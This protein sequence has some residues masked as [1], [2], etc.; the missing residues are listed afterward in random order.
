MISRLWYHQLDVYD[1]VR[2]LGILLNL[3]RSSPG[4]ERLFIADFFLATP[5]LLHK[6]TMSREMRHELNKLSILKPSK[7]FIDYPSGYLLFDK[8]ESVQNEAMKALVGKGL[9]CHEELER[10]VVE[11]TD[12]G[13]AVF[14][15]SFISSDGENGIAFFIA[16]E[17]CG[18]E[19]IGNRDLRRRSGLRRSLT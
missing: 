10:G 14:G 12:R 3:F 11:F 19:E 8:M 5:Q 9:V 15:D 16:Q 17:F 6:T 2:R 4:M 7:S 18:V 13:G 1:T